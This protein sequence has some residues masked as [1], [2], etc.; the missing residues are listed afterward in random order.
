M[1]A[2]RSHP[3]LVGLVALAALAAAAHPA[4]AKQSIQGAAILDHPCGKVAV[5]HMGL[6]HAGK[7][8]EAVRLGTKEMQSQWNAMSAEDRKM[9]SGMMQA[10]AQSEADFSAAIKA[11]GELVVDGNNATLTVKTT[12]HDANGSSTETMTERYV[13]DGS[14]CAI[15]H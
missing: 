13:I 5:Q 4:A 8:D 1:N 3:I 7:I 15:T 12:T 6:V 2:H 10:T 11:S 9:F 14:T